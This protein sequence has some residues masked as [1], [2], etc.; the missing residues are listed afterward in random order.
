[1]VTCLVCSP[2][3]R[4][5]WCIIRIVSSSRRH[6]GDVVAI[7]RNANSS[8]LCSTIAK[9]RSC[10]FHLCAI[11][12]RMCPASSNIDQCDSLMCPKSLLN[13]NNTRFLVLPKRNSCLSKVTVAGYL[14]DEV[15]KS[16]FAAPLALTKQY[17]FLSRSHF[18]ARKTSLV[19]SHAT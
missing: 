18:E 11:S 8:H 12:L 1:M 9:V 14:P 19:R 17:L 6:T 15:Q 3:W 13:A 16:Y 4:P 5:Y 2:F 7:D 10:C